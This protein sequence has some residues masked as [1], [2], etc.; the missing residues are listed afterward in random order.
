MG[1]DGVMVRLMSVMTI[2]YLLHSSIALG[3]CDSGGNT[4][5]CVEWGVPSL[6]RVYHTKVVVCPLDNC[7]IILL[8]CN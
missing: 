2:V 4:F 6:P 7:G 8:G 1:W 3:V 5:E